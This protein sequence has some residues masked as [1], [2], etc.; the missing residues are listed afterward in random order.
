[1]RQHTRV[2]R[3]CRLCGTPAADILR[4][5]T[6][7]APSHSLTTLVAAVAHAAASR[8]RDDQSRIIPASAEQEQT[9]LRVG[10]LAVVRR[11]A[12]ETRVER[13]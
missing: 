11:A 2:R 10:E 7:S 1:M 13:H 8:A 3:L 9:L 5:N 6:P 4:L 12:G